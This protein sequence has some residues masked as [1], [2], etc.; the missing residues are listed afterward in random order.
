VFCIAYYTSF[1]RN[2]GIFSWESE[3]CVFYILSQLFISNLLN[4]ARNTD[5]HRSRRGWEGSNMMDV[6]GRIYMRCTSL[7]WLRMEANGE[8]N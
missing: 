1:S 4:E 2:S 7:K 8:D 5:K 6:K 3:N